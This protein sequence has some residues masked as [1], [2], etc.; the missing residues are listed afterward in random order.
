MV[1]GGRPRPASAFD[2]YMPTP[3]RSGIR[4]RMHGMR[5]KHVTVPAAQLL[6]LRASFAHER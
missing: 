6:A 1:T 4:D 3:G 2:Q 5:E